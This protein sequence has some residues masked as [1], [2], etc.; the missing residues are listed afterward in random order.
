MVLARVQ[1]QHKRRE[2][3]MTLLH[4]RLRFIQASHNYIVSLLLILYF[5]QD[6]QFGNLGVFS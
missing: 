1:R 2:V 4:P 3:W 6:V 5:V